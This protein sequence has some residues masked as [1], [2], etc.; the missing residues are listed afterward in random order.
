VVLEVRE[1][2]REREN[3]LS[4]REKRTKGWETEK[5]DIRGKRLRG[6]AKKR[7][8]RGCAPSVY[9]EHVEFRTKVVATRKS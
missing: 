2:E 1:R 7:R 3:I 6:G 4:A 9:R 8:M 5:E